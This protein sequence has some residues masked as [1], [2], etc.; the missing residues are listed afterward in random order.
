M[1]SKVIFINL[2]VILLLLVF[3][4]C[5][6]NSPRQKRDP[7]KE[8]GIEYPSEI[9]GITLF[10]VGDAPDITNEKQIKVIV[11]AITNANRK[12]YYTIILNY[13]IEFH[14]GAHRRFMEFDYNPDSRIVFFG[15]GYGSEELF[16]I[17]ERYGKL[18]SKNPS[19]PIRYPGLNS[20]EDTKTP[21]FYPPEDKLEK[22][23]MRPVI[24]QRNK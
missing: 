5:T 14:I 17:L 11:D 9:T 15:D 10:K 6:K 8:A 16:N 21:I 23:P 24:D 18:P 19:P 22:T 3:N 12:R 13:V 1:K 2:F 4:S 20:S 7:W